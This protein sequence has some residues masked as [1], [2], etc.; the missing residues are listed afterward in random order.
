MCGVEC[1]CGCHAC[2]AWN[3]TAGT[4]KISLNEMKCSNLVDAFELV[5][6]H[7]TR[8]VRPFCVHYFEEILQAFLRCVR[9]G[10]LPLASLT[11]C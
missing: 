10:T 5:G 11:V 7:T 2:V 8:N 4:T 1:M 3:G 9:P 6:T